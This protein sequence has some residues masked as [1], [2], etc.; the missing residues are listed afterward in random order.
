VRKRTQILAASG[1]AIA[2][3]APGCGSDKEGKPIPQSSA[4]VLDNQLN[5]IQSRVDAGAC[6][7]VTD[8]S[9]PNTTVVQNTINRLPSD[10][11]KDVR[12]ALEESFRNLF[13]LVR[14]QCENTNTDTTPTETTPPTITETPT[15]TQTA[16]PETTT[17]P[18]TNTTPEKK[19][20]KPKDGGG[21]GQ[22][23]A[24]AN[25]GGE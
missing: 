18:Q 17:T 5:S 4:Q 10:V 22:G 2:L 23:G 21:N 12:D 16:P 1:C 20:K 6:N 13:Q 3:L 9:D 19:P 7:D 8:G 11:D 14:D 25:P 24:Q 15:V